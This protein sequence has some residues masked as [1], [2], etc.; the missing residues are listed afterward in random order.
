MSFGLFLSSDDAAVS[1]AV[2]G[3]DTPIGTGLLPQPDSQ[4]TK[5]VVPQGKRERL[6]ALKEKLIA[7]GK[8]PA[9]T[10]PKPKLTRRQKYQ[11]QLK[12][13]EEAYTERVAAAHSTLFLANIPIGTSMRQLKVLCKPYGK[14]LS[15]RIRSVAYQTTE[16]GQGKHKAPKKPLLAR[17]IMAIKG[18]INE[19]RDTCNGY[20]HFEDPAC[21]D[22]AIGAL[23]GTLFRD[24]HLIADHADGGGKL[25][26]HFTVFI[27]GLPKTISE[28]RL[29]RWFNQHEIEDIDHVRIVRNPKTGLGLGFGYVSFKNH[30]TV[31][32]AISIADKTLDEREIRIVKARE[33]PWKK[34]MPPGHW[35]KRERLTPMGAAAAGWRP[36]L[37]GPG[38]REAPSGPN[39]TST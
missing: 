24:H 29:W 26:C 15:T 31:R 7:E 4:Y 10:L 17:K 9:L 20:V 22:V 23:H 39:C 32:K 14:V 27:G 1:S 25:D 38:T 21:V 8:D 35:Q 30:G 19:E 13:A 37:Q 34:G 6:R 2:V 18:L 33:N 11:Q 36:S 12:R 28:E 3:D 5:L 16:K